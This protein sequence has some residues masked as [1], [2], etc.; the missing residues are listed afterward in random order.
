MATG[1][2]TQHI[3]K[4][5]CTI[6]LLL[7]VSSLFAQRISLRLKNAQL[8]EAFKQIESK[9]SYRFTY[10][11]EALDGTSRVSLDINNEPVESAIKKIF[12]GQP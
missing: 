1:K 5:L 11:N 12:D 7:Y 3:L 9:T 6:L 8:E 2:R 10:V 4:L